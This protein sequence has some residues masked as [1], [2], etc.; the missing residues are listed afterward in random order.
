MNRMIFSNDLPNQV[1]KK[2]IKKTERFYQQKTVA[3]LI[4][5][6]VYLKAFKIVEGIAL[7]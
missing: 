7:I 4:Q 1:K 2:Q 3:E 5:P 6:S